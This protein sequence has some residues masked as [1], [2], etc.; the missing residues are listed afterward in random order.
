[1]PSALTRALTIVHVGQFP[2]GLRPG[3]QHGVPVKLSNGLTRNGHLV[4]DFSDRDVARALSLFGNRKMGRKP[5][6]AALLAFCRHHRPDVLL[7]GHADVIAAETVAAIREALPGIRIAQWNVDPLFEPDNIRRISGK[8]DV[9]DATFVSTAGAPMRALREGGRKVAF[10]PNPVDFSIE[11]G[12]SDLVA[13]PP[14]DVFYACGHPS[15]PLRVICGQEWDMDAFARTLFQRLPGL[16]PVFGGVLGRPH[17]TGG[18]YQT[19]LEACAIGLNISRRADHYLYSSDRMAQ[20][21]GN[22]LV[23][24]MER[25]TGFGDIFSD[26]EIAFFSNFDE[27]VAQI[28]RLRA[29]TPARQAMASGGR[30]R[31]HALFNEQAVAARL[32]DV[33]LDDADVDAEPWK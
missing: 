33:L 27:L 11:R 12:R 22:G 19:A 23:V 24:M 25:S 1:M 5:A 3:F 2:F 7:L 10:M 4:L 16:D 17:L 26:D 15:R 18:G 31:Y 28:D 9:V 13:H 6:N 32:L 29:D 21:A 14:H 8:L 30:S 20:L